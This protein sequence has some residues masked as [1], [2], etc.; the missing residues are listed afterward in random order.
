[1]QHHTLSK[2]VILAG[3]LLLMS[4]ASFTSLSFA[5][6]ESLQNASGEWVD[7]KYKISGDWKIEKRGE[8]HVIVFG[9]RFKT[10]KGPD[11]KV[12]WSPQSMASVTGKTAT[13]GA[14]LLGILKSN[15]GA[16][17]YVLPANIDV[18]A[19]NSILIHCEQY[20]VLWGGT[21]I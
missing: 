20:S 2:H 4:I 8:Q 3:F 15:K 14:V 19:T 16:Q 7:K 18:T 21:E 17:E 11:L 5:S 12:F 13:D 1:M 9:D 10:K 6:T